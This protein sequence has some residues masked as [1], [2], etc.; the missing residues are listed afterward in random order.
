MDVNDGHEP[1]ATEV[2][3]E[4]AQAESP[5]RK[6][7]ELTHKGPRPKRKKKHVVAGV[8]DTHARIAR[9]KNKRNVALGSSRD[10]LQ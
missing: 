3:S 4:A 1:D 7:T 9:L 10:E 8:G 6:E 5:P 2:D